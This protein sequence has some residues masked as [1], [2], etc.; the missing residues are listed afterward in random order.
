MTHGTQVVNL[1]RCRFRDNADE[2]RG[3]TQVAVV[4]K[5]LD[6]GVVPVAVQMVNTA[7]VET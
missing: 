3:I 1:V 5:E 7:G 4:E 6:M 2:V